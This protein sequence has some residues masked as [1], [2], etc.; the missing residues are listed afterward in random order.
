MAQSYTVKSGDTLS[1]I[2]RQFGVTVDGLV[3][4]NNIANPSLIK[5]GQVL[6][7]PDAVTPSPPAPSPIGR[8]DGGEG[9]PLPKPEI[10]GAPF[11]RF[12][13]RDP[14]A[15]D[16]RNLIANGSMGPGHHD[17]AWGT[18]VDEWEPF[19]VSG[20]PPNF[21]WVDNEQIDPGGSQQIYSY[22]KFD[23]GVRQTVRNLKPGAF[24]MIRWGYSLAAKSYDGPNVRVKT[25]GRKLGVDPYGGTD[26][27]SPNVVWGPDYF[28]GIGAL[29]LPAM[30]TVFSAMSDKATI[31]LRALAIEA[32]GG[33]NR[34]WID[35][36]CM[37]ERAEIPPI[38]VKTQ[39]APVQ[40]P[41]PPPA[42]P[43]APPSGTAETTYTVRSGDT[44]FGIARKFSV[45][46]Q[47]IQQANNIANPSLIKPG[48]V[49]KIPK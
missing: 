44:L 49:L 48:Q 28:D 24:Y 19:V 39:P 32:D 31:F 9:A 41:T 47:A 20:A 4:A 30:Q 46:V 40:P 23:A 26:A 3:K 35:A 43:P 12:V 21:R 2:A 27:N 16:P 22:E 36:I 8:G 11:P 13:L 15:Q 7:I 25:V 14:C 45:T 38:E 34:V 33:E 37:E 10:R 29:N 1:K 6:T 17:H 42:Q 5:P 18:V